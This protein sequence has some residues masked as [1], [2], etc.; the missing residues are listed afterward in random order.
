[1]SSC[2]TILAV[3]LFVAI[4]LSALT[5]GCGGG[6]GWN[7]KLNTPLNIRWSQGG[8]AEDTFTQYVAAGSDGTIYAF[9]SS[10]EFKNNSYAPYSVYALDPHNGGIRWRFT[11]EESINTKKSLAKAHWYSTTLRQEC[12]SILPLKTQS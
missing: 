12:H 10:R 6:S 1:M 11:A 3:V 7:S 8:R 5:Q 9:A 2:N 4:G